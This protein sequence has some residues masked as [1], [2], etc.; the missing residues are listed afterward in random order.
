MHEHDP[1]GAQLDQEYGIREPMSLLAP[2]AQGGRSALGYALGSALHLVVLLL[3]P[4]DWET[5][6]LLAAVVLS[7]CVTSV[8]IA[9]SAG[10]SVVRALVRTVGIGMASMLISYIAGLVVF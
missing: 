4:Q 2:C 3:Y 8:L 5:R 9:M 10:S 1:L 7:L 6:A